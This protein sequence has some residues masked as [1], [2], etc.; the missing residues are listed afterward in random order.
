MSCHVARRDEIEIEIEMKVVGRQ[1][2]GETVGGG[3][4]IEK[5][6]YGDDGVVAEKDVSVPSRERRK[7][8][9]SLTTSWKHS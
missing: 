4:Q 5:G 9:K 1:G 3:Q 2:Q 6:L 8:N 7:A